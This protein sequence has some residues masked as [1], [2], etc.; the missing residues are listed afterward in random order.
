MDLVS[1]LKS[2]RIYELEPLFKVG[3]KIERLGSLFNIGKDL[4]TSFKISK[5]LRT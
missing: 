5:D 4:Q 1:H 3:E 2:I